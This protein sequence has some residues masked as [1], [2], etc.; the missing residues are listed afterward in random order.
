MSSSAD[1]QLLQIAVPTTLSAAEFTQIAGH[2][3]KE[4]KKT[5][6]SA[7]EICPKVSAPQA[8]DSHEHFCS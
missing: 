3:S 2:T 1:K 5:V 4:G 6:V 8:E 7:E